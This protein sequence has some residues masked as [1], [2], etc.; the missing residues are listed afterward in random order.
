[1]YLS[2]RV[3]HSSMSVDVK[4]GAIVDPSSLKGPE[5]SYVCCHRLLRDNPSPQ[6]Q[7]DK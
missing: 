6:W 5:E 7:C 3:S 4:F 1:M 2:S